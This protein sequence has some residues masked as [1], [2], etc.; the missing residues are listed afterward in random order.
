MTDTVQVA[1][2]VGATGIIV[3]F[4][5]RNHNQVNGRMTELIEA[6][7]KAAKAEGVKQEK[8]NPS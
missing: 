8:D 3:A 1:L 5:Q 4:L 6:T 2:I 7:R